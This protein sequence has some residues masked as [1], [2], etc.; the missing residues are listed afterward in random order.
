[1]AINYANLF[2]ELGEIVEAVNTLV[3]SGTDWLDQLE[4]AFTEIS[5]QYTGN[6]REDLLDNVNTVINGVKTSVLASAGSIATLATTRLQDRTTILDEL[7][8][9]GNNTAVQTILTELIRQMKDDSESI[10]QSV[11]S[12]FIVTVTDSAGANTGSVAGH[13]ILSGVA[14]PH[15]DWSANMDYQGVASDLFYDNEM[16]TFTC[17]NDSESGSAKEGDESFTLTG[18]LAK[19][20][21]WKRDQIGSGL[22][23]T[24]KPLNGPT[25][26]FI[27]NADFELFSPA[28]VPENWTIKSGL[29]GTDIIEVSG[30][31]DV[32]HGKRALKLVADGTTIPMQLEQDFAATVL[33]PNSRL[34]MIVWAKDDGF[35]LGDLDIDL[36]DDST[37]SSYLS[38]LSEG[39]SGLTTSYALYA[40]T[41]AVGTT[42]PDSL[43]LRL[44]L[45]GTPTSGKQI[46]ID[47]IGLGIPTYHGG[48]GFYVY[49]G[50]DRFLKND[51]FKIQ[52]VYTS[53]GVFQS[54]FREYYHVQLP[55]SGSPTRA[56][57]LASD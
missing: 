1:M 8:Q 22:G 15:S 41:A 50:A 14:K 9:L 3:N 28:N 5:A 27:K 55:K 13:N 43:T 37:G 45:T 53:E 16:F 10:Q 31:T 18:E 6:V 52:P 17:I 2:A 36:I 23:P 20:T 57:S 29:A 48:T 7:P 19:T 32:H 21:P 12:T 40:G 34:V 33:T 54:F 47:Y 4:T 42:V 24:V 49:A 26:N 44:A 11:L 30:S 39:L 46:W 35:A 56:D 38:L 25:N 51:R